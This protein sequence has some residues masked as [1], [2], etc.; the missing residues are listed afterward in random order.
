M[1]GAAVSTLKQTSAYSKM[2]QHVRFTAGTEVLSPPS[3]MPHV[4]MTGNFLCHQSIQVT[5]QCEELQAAW[6]S[7]R[8]AGP[9]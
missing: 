1:L 4:S 5:K 3:S 9:L 2:K 6:E 7:C 8:L